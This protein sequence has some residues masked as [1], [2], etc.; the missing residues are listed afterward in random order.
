MGPGDTDPGHGE[1][2]VQRQGL[3]EQLQRAVQILAA[4][5]LPAP[6]GGQVELVGLGTESDRSL[7]LERI[8]PRMEGGLFLV[9]KVIE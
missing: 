3:V 2:R 6:D 9:P 7:E 8:A 4:M 1:T 5:A